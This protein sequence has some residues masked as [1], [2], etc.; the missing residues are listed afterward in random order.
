VGRS[1]DGNETPGGRRFCPRV[2]R[3]R[4]AS[5]QFP[6][7]EKRIFT[8][9]S[10]E[11]EE[12]MRC[13][14]ASLLLWVTFS[15]SLFGFARWG[16]RGVERR[17]HPHLAQRPLP[18]GAE[19]EIVRLPVSPPVPTNVQMHQCR[20]IRD[21][22]RIETNPRSRPDLGTRP[23]KRA[24]VIDGPV[25]HAVQTWFETVQ[26]LSRP[27][28]ALIDAAR[29]EADRVTQRAATVEVSRAEAKGRMRTV[30]LCCSA[31]LRDI[32]FRSWRKPMI[33]C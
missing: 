3:N 33:L 21:E 10:R 16:G 24:R 26:E 28:R 17:R 4:R 14:S 29:V 8:Q 12:R 19:Y 15:S 9:S 13:S 31:S 6:G 32:Q 27:T 1:R 25:E 5:R 30:F 20:R 7:T 23:G 2:H 22:N 18:V 11:A